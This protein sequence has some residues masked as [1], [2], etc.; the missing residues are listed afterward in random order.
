MCTLAYSLWL[1]VRVF[2]Y[3]IARQPVASKPERILPVLNNRAGGQVK[4]SFVLRRTCCGFETRFFFNRATCDSLPR[5]LRTVCD[6]FSLSR[7]ARSEKHSKQS[8]VDFLYADIARLVGVERTEL[9]SNPNTTY[10][11]TQPILIVVR[12][13]L[14][15]VSDAVILFGFYFCQGHHCL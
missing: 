4:I 2:L 14:D 3:R 8:L 6:G 5:L 11:H 9:L 13:R 15:F 12:C 10:I 1:C 7:T